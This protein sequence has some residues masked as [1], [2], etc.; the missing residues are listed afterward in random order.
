MGA[1]TY[2]NTIHLSLF[3][4]LENRFL[5]PRHANARSLALRP[6]ALFCLCMSD[7]SMSH[8]DFVS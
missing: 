3:A 6:D 8:I 1:A 7:L 5:Q 4:L 2:I